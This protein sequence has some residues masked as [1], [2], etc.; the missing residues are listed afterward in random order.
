MGFGQ[1]CSVF[2][3]LFKLFWKVG[4][5]LILMT[6]TVLLHGF[7]HS[8]IMLFEYLHTF[9]GV[10]I[11]CVFDEFL[12]RICAPFWELLGVITRNFSM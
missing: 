3:C 12:G 5:T 11:C 8:N 7:T 4:E 1:F 9:L 6:L 2:S 10:D